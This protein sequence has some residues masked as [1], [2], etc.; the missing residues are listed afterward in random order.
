MKNLPHLAQP[1]GWARLAFR[2]PIWLY[3]LR[4]GWLLGDRF[5]LLT[6]IGRSSGQLRQTVL[7]VLRHDRA[8]GTYII[9]SGFGP[10]ADWFRNIQKTPRVLVMSGGERWEATAEQLSVPAAHDEL[11]DYARRH[12]RALRA[13][14]RL[15]IGEHLT[16]SSESCQRLAE[17]I[18]LVALRPRQPAYSNQR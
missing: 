16:G 13:L 10:Q 3:R 11:L 9:A 15:M 18:P 5:L 12:P 17:R 7:E 4:L 1:R 14:S 2:L 6:H 8:S